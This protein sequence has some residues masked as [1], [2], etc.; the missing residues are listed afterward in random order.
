LIQVDSLHCIFWERISGCEVELRTLDKAARYRGIVEFVVF[1]IITILLLICYVRS[2]LENPGEIPRDSEDWAYR[3]PGTSINNPSTVIPPTHT[4]E[5]KRS[6]ERRHCKWCGKYKPDRCHHCRVCRTCILKM[7]HHCPWIY[8][9]VGFRNY[10]YFFLLLFYSVLDCHFI[11][12]SMAETVMTLVEEELPFMSMFL[13]LFGETLAFFLGVL[14]TM[15]FGFHIW[16]MT[17]SMTTIE[18]CEKSLP[19]SR[20]TR[21]EKVT[22]DSSVYD[23]GVIGNLKSVLG[24]NILTW[25]L[26]GYPPLGDGLSFISDDSRLTLDPENPHMR[27]KSH[28]TVPRKHKQYPGGD[29]ATH[30]SMDT[31]ILSQASYGGG[32][33]SVR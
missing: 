10:K 27:K 16:L 12:W 15:F 28:Q 17:K 24:E 11:V 8:N 9:C 29:D 4:Q 1:H 13:V 5:A 32:G 25:C 23:R 14:T 31:D 6:G 3:P 7:D 26:P 21:S 22:Y 33:G 18:F 30:R 19:K 20:E 2:I